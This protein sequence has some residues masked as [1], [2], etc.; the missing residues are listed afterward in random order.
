MKRISLLP[1][2]LVLII[3][4]LAAGCTAP[5]RSGTD[6]GV[7]Q[8]QSEFQPPGSP[9][10]AGSGLSSGTSPKRFE[11]ICEEGESKN[12]GGYTVLRDSRTGK[13]YLVITGLNGAPTVININ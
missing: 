11:V 4:L 7:N 10:P 13:E 8:V 6:P 3:A 5:D 1:F 9:P 12:I 2:L